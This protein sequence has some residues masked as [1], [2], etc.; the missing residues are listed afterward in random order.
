MKKHFAL[1]VLCDFFFSIFVFAS[2]F[3]PVVCLYIESDSSN[4]FTLP[5]SGVLFHSIDNACISILEEVLQRLVTSIELSIFL[6]N[7]SKTV[8]GF[9]NTSVT[10]RKENRKMP[11]KKPPIEKVRLSFML[12]YIIFSM[13]FS[14][15]VQ[16]WCAFFYLLFETR[17][18]CIYSGRVRLFFFFNIL[19]WALHFL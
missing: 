6:L 15:W 18:R 2:K 17:R 5:I 4:F 7:T 9:I 1:F 14:F 19:R 12:I 3:E 16:R 8:P 11:V 13:L 10:M